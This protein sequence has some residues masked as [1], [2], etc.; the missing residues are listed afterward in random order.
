MVE[1]AAAARSVYVDVREAILSL[2]TPVPPKG[3]P[4]ALE[5]YSGQYAESSKLAVRFKATPEAAQAPLTA[6]VQSEVFRIVK[7]SLT[8]VRKHASAHRVTITMSRE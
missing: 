4:Y 7:E 6:V 8:N 2:S 5:D 3:L 1:L